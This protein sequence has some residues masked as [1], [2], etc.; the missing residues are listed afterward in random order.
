MKNLFSMFRFLTGKKHWLVFSFLI[1]AVSVV[2]DVVQP[3][4]IEWVIDNG[5]RDRTLRIVL[6]GSASMLGLA[7]VSAVSN[8]FSGLMLTKSGQYLGYELRNTIYRK[9]M[10]LSFENLDHWRTGELMVRMNSDVNT[11]RMFVRMGIMMIARSVIMILGS[12]GIMYATNVR[13]ATVMAV[14][15][16]G[17]VLLFFFIATRIR[18]LFTKVRERLDDLNNVLQENLAGAKL[19][20]SFSRQQYE[21]DRFGVRNRDFYRASLKIG[22]VTSILFPL[23]MFIGQVALIATLWVGGG[24]VIE[25]MLNPAAQGLTLGQL[26][27]FNNYAIMAMFPIFMLGSVLNFISMAAASAQRIQD[28]LDE[29]SPIKEVENPK[30]KERLDGELEFQD[31]TFRYGKGDPAISAISLKIRAGENIGILGPT[32]SGKS[33]LAN[34]IPRF[35]DPE[36]GRVLIDGLNVRSY[37]FQ[38]LRR[39]ITMVLQETVLFSRS[40]RENVAFG[41]E[42]ADDQQIRM[43][44]DISCASEFI[45]EKEYGLDE[46]VGER[47]AGLSGGQRQRVAI[48]RALVSDPDILILDDAT[49]SVDLRTERELIDNLYRN[50]KHRTTIIISQKINAVRQADRIVLFKEGR[51]EAVGSHD[52]LMASSAMYREIFDTQS[53]QLQ[54]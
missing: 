26:I 18:P 3:K 44:C 8:G 49:S 22:Y 53:A 6:T 13:L 33:T 14:I 45:A 38:T 1:L 35:Y 27:A 9:V 42:N 41:K 29:D 40:I 25:T 36:A 54:A 34:L 48:A 43:A 32:G 20:R 15:M 7:V 50:R 39:P 21:I 17:T 11:I 23:L 46:H 51:I 28:L 30:H 47:G 2:L 12:L 4:F 52:E 31:V 37:D 24:E 10:G 5:I 16:P 19:V